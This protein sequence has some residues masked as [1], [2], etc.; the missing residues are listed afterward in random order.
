MNVMVDNMNN[1]GDVVDMPSTHCAF[2]AFFG[3]ARK[4]LC[5]V[6]GS[7]IGLDHSMGFLSNLIM[8]SHMRLHYILN[9]L[10]W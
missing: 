2:W 4:P 5:W 7:H 3:G 1:M 6:V 9:I 8:G 10:N